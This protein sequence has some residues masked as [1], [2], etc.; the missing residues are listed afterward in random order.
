M[1]PTPERSAAEW[2]AS[3][4]SARPWAWTWTCASR[5]HRRLNPAEAVALAAQLEPLLPMFYEDPILPDNFDSWP[6]GPEDRIPAG[7][8]RA[9]PH[10]PGV[11]DAGKAPGSG[12]PAGQHLRVRRLLP[13]RKRSRPIAEAN[14]IG[15]IP[16]N[17]LSQLRRRPAS[18]ST[19]PPPASPSR[20][21]GPGRPGGPRPALCSKR[22]AS[23][24]SALRIS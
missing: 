3:A 13:G 7:H 10:A 11:P 9:H 2:S 8:R 24:R 12:L 4:K 17:P 20:S 6:G 19:R 23:P 14:Q 15:I 21:T 18:S 22:P 5:T 1:R 16:H